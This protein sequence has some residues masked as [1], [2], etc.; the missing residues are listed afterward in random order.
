MGF[1]NLAEKTIN[2]KLVYY[3]CGMGGKTT[4]LQVVH[5]IMC[6]RNEV[7]LVSIKTEEDATLLF[8][9][10][11][12]DLGNVEGFTVRIQGFT[13]PG[14][15]KYRRMRRYVLSGADAVVFVVDSEASRLDENLQSF[16]SLLENLREN[17]LDPDSIPLVVQ[18]NKRDLDD[19]LSEEELDSRFLVRPDVVAFP[20]VATRGNGVFEAFVEAA[21]QLVEQKIRTYGLG[22]GQVDP[23]QVA[24]GAR[25]R[26]WEI[27]DRSEFAL[28]VRGEAATTA[29]S[30]ELTIDDLGG[31]APA[32]IAET[33]VDDAAILTEEDLA[34]ALPAASVTADAP[35]PQSDDQ[36]ALRVDDLEPL[37]ELLDASV[38]SNL[39]L[40]QRFGE[41]DRY[42]TL[43]EQKNRELVEVAQDVVHDLNRPLSALRLMLSSMKKGYCGKIDETATKAVDNGLRAVQM[44]DRLIQDLLESSRLEFDGIRLEFREVDL[45]AVVASV[46]DTLQYEIEEKGVVVDVERLPRVRCDEWA[47]TR[48]FANLLGNAIQYSSPERSPRVHVSITRDPGRWRLMVS[49]NGIGIPAG[50]VDRLFQRFERGSNTGGISG[51]G[52]GLHIV[53]EIL[54][55]HGG[56]VSVESVESSGT[57]FFLDLPLEPVQPP[58]SRVSD[59]ADP[60]L[61]PASPAQA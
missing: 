59:A 5:E 15:P 33:A 51:T 7:R 48:V 24:S 47:M 26:L 42:R 39:E 44:M 46:L 43:L 11:P 27:F 31:A 32:G 3:G 34:S 57:T 23:T 18:Y 28:R 37:P 25:A 40:V 50:D 38:A 8:D 60:A 52:L 41:L 6:P 56:E 16:D 21:G 4:S 58:H 54:R 20:S 36:S 2:A 19:V 10:L 53:R 55:G 35:D 61:Q 13:V 30:V 9:F 17:G 12:I 45:D 14:Q 29:P 1:I 49:D 22:R